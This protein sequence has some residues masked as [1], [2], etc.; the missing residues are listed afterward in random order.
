[1]DKEE[2]M[3]RIAELREKRK[4]DRIE[5]IRKKQHVE[6]LRALIVMA[7]LHYER[8]LMNKYGIRP[9]KKLVA[10]KRDNVEK[11]KAHYIFQLKK[12]I[13][14]HL[15]WY[16]EDMIFER[17]YKAEDF[18]RK[19]I[20]KKAFEG[21][22]QVHTHTQPNLFPIFYILPVPQSTCQRRQA[23]CQQSFQCCVRR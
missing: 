1:M 14:Y 16:T 11:A 2:K 20:L 9:L 7:D 23:T 3:R 17:N 6:K 15:M 21:W 22:K 5:A 4:K 19:K 8:Y 18:H 13:F 10:I 12:N